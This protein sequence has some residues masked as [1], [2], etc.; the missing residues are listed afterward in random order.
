MGQTWQKALRVLTEQLDEKL[1]ARLLRPVQPHLIGD[2]LELYVPNEFV[3][4]EL[5]SKLDLLKEAIGQEYKVRLLVGESPRPPKPN[6]PEK[7]HRQGSPLETEIASDT[8]IGKSSP[9]GDNA[10]QGVSLR[11]HLGSFIVDDGNREAIAAIE[12]LING[13]SLFN[14]LVIGVGVS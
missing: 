5:H 6:P 4:R 8:F 10:K 14:F 2:T 9:L 7:D 1:V 12:G 13:D 11:D 3:R